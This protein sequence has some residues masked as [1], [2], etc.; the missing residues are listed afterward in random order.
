MEGGTVYILHEFVF[1]VNCFCCPLHDFF[2]VSRG[3]IFYCHN[4][5][6]LRILERSSNESFLSQFNTAV[7]LYRGL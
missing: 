6:I 4:I 5:I 3:G 2:L 7:L 1:R